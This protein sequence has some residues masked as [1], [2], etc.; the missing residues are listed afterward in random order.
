MN[1]E[2]GRLLAVDAI[3][4]RFSRVSVPPDVELR[5]QTRMHEFCRQPETVPAQTASSSRFRRFLP[6]CVAALAAAVVL[7]ATVVLIGNRDAWA[8]VAKS[9]QLKPWVRWTLQGPDGAPLHEGLRPPETWFSARHRVVARRFMNAVQYVDIVHQ[10]TYDYDPI[11]NTV[12]HSLTGD[13]DNVDFGHLEVLLRLVAE[14]DQKLKLPESPI[15]IVERTWRE[16]LDR[17]RPWIEFTFQCRDPRRTFPEY[18]MTF[19]VDPQSRLVVEMRSTERLLSNDTA[20]VRTYAVDYPESGPDD[21]H[22]LGV[23]RNAVI[24][25]RR[26]A[27]SRDACRSGRTRT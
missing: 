27:R 14:G 22:A 8:Q 15:Q 5:L 17:N 21:I 7:V 18:S 12:I 11:K 6:T 26:R 9:L 4:E 13:D 20:E 3:L 25:D 1:Q 24:V 10:E 19:R 16:V 2:N 23:P